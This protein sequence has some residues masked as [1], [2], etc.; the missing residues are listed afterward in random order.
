MTYP[1]GNVAQLAEQLTFNQSVVGSNPTV[2]TIL[3]RRKMKTVNY[4]HNSYTIPNEF[5]QY[6]LFD[7]ATNACF[8]FWCDKVEEAIKFAKEQPN[9][10]E[11]SVMINGQRISIGVDRK[12]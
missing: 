11:L 6:R 12:C 1:L 7:R 10:L 9:K 2:P 5:H 8:D 4:E 3:F